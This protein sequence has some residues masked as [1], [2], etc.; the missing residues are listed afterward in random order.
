MAV[1]KRGQG[2]CDRCEKEFVK[3]EAKYAYGGKTVCED[4]LTA[5]SEENQ[6]CPVCGWEYDES[7]PNIS[8]RLNPMNSPL[9]QGA[10][11]VESVVLICPKCRCFFFDKFEHAVTLKILKNAEEQ[12][13]LKDEN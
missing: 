9:A 13:R 1:L 11:T 12:Q 6:I 7:T 5:L 10:N 2:K 4:C 8:V 3:G